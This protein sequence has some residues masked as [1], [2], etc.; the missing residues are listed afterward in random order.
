MQDLC[1]RDLFCLVSICTWWIECLYDEIRG[2]GR[3]FGPRYNVKS[4]EYL[5]SP[6]LL[7][8]H[9]FI[10]KSCCLSP[11]FPIEWQGER[12]Y[13]H[14]RLAHRRMWLDGAKASIPILQVKKLRPERSRLCRLS[15]RVWTWI[16]V[17]STDRKTSSKPTP[18]GFSAPSADQSFR[19]RQERRA[20]HCGLSR[21]W[22]LGG[23][24]ES[25]T[26]MEFSREWVCCFS[27]PSEA[28]RSGQ[29]LLSLT[30]P[31]KQLQINKQT[32]W[33]IGFCFSKPVVIKMNPHSATFITFN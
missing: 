5:S 8:N 14:L 3:S 9:L 20:L 4:T 29:I 26:E 19:E 27:A 15:G 23:S 33:I 25:S 12:N 2:R 13:I 18:T 10:F 1:G 7:G 6:L 32:L 22:P 31:L 21:E 11:S 16:R 28:V 17:L 24:S 30:D